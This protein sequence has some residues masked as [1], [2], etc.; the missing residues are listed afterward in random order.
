M[1]RFDRELEASGV[2]AATRVTYMNPLRALG[3]HLGKPYQKMVKTDL[4]SFFSGW[5]G[6][7]KRGTVNLYKA[8]VKRFGKWLA[9]GSLNGHEYPQSVQWIR[10]KGGYNGELPVKAEDI[11]WPKDVKRLL[12]KCYMPRDKALIISLYESAARASEWLGLNVKS[13]VFDRVGCYVTVQGKTGGRRIRLVHSTPY[14]Q[15]WINHHPLKGNRN[16]PLWVNMMGRG[17][18]T[19][20][21]LWALVKKIKGRLPEVQKPLHPHIFR[22]SRLTFLAKRLTAIELCTF[23]G[24]SINGRNISRIIRRYIH[25]SGEDLDDKILELSGVERDKRPPLKDLA[26]QSYRCLR[27]GNQNP[28]DAQYCY[29][30][31]LILDEEEALTAQRRSVF[32]SKIYQLLRDEPKRQQFLT[33]LENFEVKKELKL[34]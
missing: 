22:H 21:G 33:F 24:W 4:I 17:R 8:K 7:L 32:E 20:D 16:A 14:L 5:N 25:L 12:E 19:Y 27:C 1:Q 9:T 10:V 18:L 34:D 11:W 2:T 29:R 3:I 31:G 26:L 15:L 30:C 13:V 6:R 28:G 23:A